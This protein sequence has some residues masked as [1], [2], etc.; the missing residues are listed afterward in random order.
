MKKLDKRQHTASTDFEP[1]EGGRTLLSSNKGGM[2]S[3]SL[4]LGI[5]PDSTQDELISILADILVEAFMWQY[6]HGK[7][8][9]TTGSSL[10]PGIDKR[11]S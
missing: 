11:T 8:H 1:K 4:D 6:E 3:P 2:R 5:S 7:E 9:T 10:L